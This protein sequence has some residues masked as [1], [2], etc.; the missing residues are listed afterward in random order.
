MPTQ[1]GQ[2]TDEHSENISKE[3]GNIKK[4]Q[5]ELNNAITKMK[6]TLEVNSRLGEAEECIHDLEDRVMEITQSKQQKEKK[7]N[8][9]ILQ[10]NIVHTNTH[11]GSRGRGEREEVENVFNEIMT[12][13]ILN[14]KKEIEIQLQKVQRTPNKMN[15]NRPTP[16]H[17]N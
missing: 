13:K 14:L 10:G 4:S 11:R 7:E 8:L 16:R 6:N 15:P 12:E 9:R 1:L 17:I 5:S 2:R 3:R